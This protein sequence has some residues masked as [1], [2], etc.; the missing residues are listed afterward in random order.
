MHIRI[1]NIM[2]YI[3]P[4]L[5]LAMLLFFYFVNPEMQHYPIKCIWKMLTGTQCPACG[6]QRMMYALV[7]GQYQEALSSNYCFIIYIPFALMIILTEWYNY[8]H[9]LN[10]L[11]KIL[12]NQYSL[13]LYIV[14]Y[15]SWWIFR[16]ILDM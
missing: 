9:K 7:H 15:F 1:D 12:Y 5:L 10:F 3:L 16:N 2:P 13:K 11:R 4:R 6:F 8:H 14:L